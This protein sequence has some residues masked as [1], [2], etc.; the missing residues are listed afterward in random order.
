MAT[1]G[2]RLDA[3]IGSRSDPR[4]VCALADYA[5]TPGALVMTDGARGG[6]VETAHGLARFESPSAESTGGAYGAGDSFAG[7][8]VYYLAGG[9]NA[10]AAAKRAAPHGAAVLSSL[11]P[12]A[13]QLALPAG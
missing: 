13:G 9:S 11:D 8:F 12:L 6:T 7:A 5:P 1:A 2:V 4:E 3:V 10:L